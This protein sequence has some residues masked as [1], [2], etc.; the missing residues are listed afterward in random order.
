MPGSLPG[1]PGI[2]VFVGIKFGGYL[3]AGA[4]LR[5]YVPAIK[6]SVLTIAAS[7][8]VLGV[9]TG[10][11]LTLLFMWSLGLVLRPGSRLE[12]GYL[13]YAFLAVAR[14]FIWAFVLFMVSDR[15]EYPASRLWV[16]AVL[17]TVWSCVLDWPGYKLAG[18]APGKWTFC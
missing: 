5:K 9:L 17:C 18:L 13:V 2:A 10:P 14:V 6:R 7:R 3:L 12:S 15:K 8:V 11:S 4:V 1:Y 16:D